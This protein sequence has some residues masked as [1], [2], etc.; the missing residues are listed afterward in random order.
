MGI[1][2]D[3]FS[4]H[5]FSGAG[6]RHHLLVRVSRP[7]FGNADEGD[8]ARVVAAADEKRRELIERYEASALAAECAGPH[9][10]ELVGELQSRPPGEELNGE[11]GGFHVELWVAATRYGRPWVLLGTAAS[12]G[13]F[14]REVE[15]DEDLSHLGARP[16][17]TRHRAYFLAGPAGGAGG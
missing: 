9:A 5:Q 15:R 2:T 11:A 4:L 12:E 14:W 1:P 16:P 17:A 6:C 8:Y 13:E 7:G 10:V 3:I